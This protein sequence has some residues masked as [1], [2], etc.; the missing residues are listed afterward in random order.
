VQP[1]A[2]RQEAPPSGEVPHLQS[3]PEL[4]AE[5]VVQ[6]VL[7]R[8]PSLV[9]MVAT[10]KAAE[11]RYPQA[12]SLEDPTFGVQVG[13]AAFGSNTIDGGYRLEVSQKYPWPGKRDLRGQNALA[14]AAAAGADVED[15]RLQLAE[16]AASAFYDYFLAERAL[17]VNRES[18]T[19]L[20]E[21]Q[22]K[23]KERYELVR[24]ANQQD[25]LQAD[26]E[27]GR[28]K[29]RLLSLE[30]GRE[31][32]VARIN[33]LMRRPPDSP[34]PPPA[35]EV[36]VE[37]ALPDVAA[38]RRLALD[39]RPDLKALADRVAADRAA[40]ALARKEYCPDVELMAAYDSFWQERQLRPQVG[41]RVNLPVR[42]ARREGAVAEAEAKLAQRQAELDRLADQVNLQVQEASAQFRESG[43]VVRL[44]EDEILRAARGNVEAAKSAYEKGKIPFVALIEA[45]R[46]LVGLQDRYHEARADYGRR[47]AN[48]ERAVG[49]SLSPDV[50]PG[51]DQAPPKLST[52]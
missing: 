18:L 33:T 9:Q 34:L 41:V 23:A 6:E 28:Q 14:E 32:A 8:N 27:I 1:A 19:L 52:P 42:V 26:V 17:E 49:G 7:A 47:R 16:S 38:L 13:P 2:Y 22:K 39:R 12:T 25:I 45:Q 29:E 24:D 31:V 44:Y 30:R 43:R 5:A 50:P 3:L 51:G 11:A 36:R 15:M 46:G 10:W 21:F 20:Q 35:R 40:L 48:L 4:T 37:G